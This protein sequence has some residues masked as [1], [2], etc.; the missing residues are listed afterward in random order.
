MIPAAMA[1]G[2]LARRA[3]EASGRGGV[4]KG[5]RRRKREREG[6]EKEKNYA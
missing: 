1:Q 3:P 5:G 4:G 6:V 2:A